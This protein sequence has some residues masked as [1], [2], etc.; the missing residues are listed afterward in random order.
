MLCAEL[1]DLQ[2]TINERKQFLFYPENLMAKNKGEFRSG[3]GMELLQ[4]YALINLLD[5]KYPVTILKDDRAFSNI[6]VVKE[7]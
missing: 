1:R 6:E 7:G 4:G 5:G 3:F 2:A